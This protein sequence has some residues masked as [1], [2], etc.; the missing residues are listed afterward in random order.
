M[1][2][3]FNRY[4]AD[5]LR[6]CGTEF[7][8]AFQGKGYPQTGDWST[9]IFKWFSDSRADGL[10]CGPSEGFPYEFIVDH[11]HATFSEG[12]SDRCDS[13]CLEIPPCGDS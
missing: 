6:T 10:C 4:S 1:G 13:V 11:Y 8:Q 7:C 5:E 12:M 9:A 2:F 3:K